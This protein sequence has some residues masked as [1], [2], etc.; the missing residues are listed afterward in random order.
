LSGM[1]RRRLLRNTFLNR[2]PARLLKTPPQGW[3]FRDKIMKT[4]IHAVARP[5]S[6][7]ALEFRVV[8]QNPAISG[9]LPFT[10][11]NGVTVAALPSGMPSV[12]QTADGRTRVF[13]RG[14]A[15]P[16]RYRGAVLESRVRDA[17]RAARDVREAV[18][19]LRLT[20]REYSP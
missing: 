1:C 19:A 2:N 13:L 17:R 3:R 14:P 8:Y 20:A 15:M 10:A 11:A 12:S 18:K 9:L 5:L 6:D 16:D 4:M 7:T